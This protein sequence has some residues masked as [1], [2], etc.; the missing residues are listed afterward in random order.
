MGGVHL[1]SISISKIWNLRKKITSNISICFMSV[2]DGEWVVVEWYLID[3]EYC[4]SGKLARR[5][6]TCLCGTKCNRDTAG[7]RVGIC[8]WWY[9][10]CWW[11]CWYRRLEWYW[12]SI[13]EDRKCPD[14]MKQ[15]VRNSRWQCPFDCNNG[16]DSDDDT[17]IQKY[18]FKKK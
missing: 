7:A 3:D 14:V 13:V 6:I 16:N 8:W 10:L 17:I 1:N 11:Y 15:I 5:I 18:L 9:R 12:W 4:C 2:A